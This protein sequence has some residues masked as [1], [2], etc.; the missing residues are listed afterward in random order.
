[1]SIN[2]EKIL[3][4]ITNE[5][6]QLVGK[7]LP[8]PDTAIFADGYLDSLNVLHLIIF[9]ESQYKIKIDPFSINLDVLG[10]INKIVDFVE[11]ILPS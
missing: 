2:R 4:E 9:I 10:S 11:G 5:V 7:D 3:T 1:M 8:S 6:T